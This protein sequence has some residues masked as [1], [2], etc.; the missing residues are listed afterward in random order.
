[1]RPK[2]GP[3]Q[4]LAVVDRMP[5]GCIFWVKEFGVLRSLR[6]LVRSEAENRDRGA[7]G[8]SQ[9]D[10]EAA[11][12]DAAEG[13]GAREAPGKKEWPQMMEL[14]RWTDWQKHDLSP[15]C[16][17]EPDAV[18]AVSLTPI[19]A[20]WEYDPAVVKSKPHAVFVGPIVASSVRWRDVAYF[21]ER[22]MIHN[23][24]VALPC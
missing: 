5:D 7:P 2:R 13:I 1:M 18:V 9:A 3:G 14:E 23:S 16:P 19:A 21:T 6:I 10:H 4:H 8:R 11:H 24:V 20:V 15:K 17:V 22:K 12:D